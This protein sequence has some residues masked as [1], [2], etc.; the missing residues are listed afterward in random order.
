[1]IGE[2]G[3]EQ[4]FQRNYFAGNCCNYSAEQALRFSLTHIQAYVYWDSSGGRGNFQLGPGLQAFTT[5]AH[6]RYLSGFA[7][8]SLKP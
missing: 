8:A 3:A 2:T 7:P 6:T 4:L 5:F 1:M